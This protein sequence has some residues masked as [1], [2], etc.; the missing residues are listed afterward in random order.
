MSTQTQRKIG[1]ASLVLLGLVFIAAVTANNALL[2]GLRFDL[3]ENNLYT[4]SPG[5]RALLSNIEEPINLYYFFSDT[6]TSDITPLRNFATRVRELLEELDA[7]A[8][9]NLN[10][11]I[12]DPV[13]FS[14]DED[15]AAQFGLQPINLGLGQAIYFGLVGTNS[16]GEEEII[17]IFNPDRER[18]LEYEI[19]R[20]VYSLARPEKVVVGLLAG[21]PMTP[22]F[23]PQMQRPTEPWVIYTQAEQLFEVR[24][25]SSSLT[26]IEEEL[27]VLWLVHPKGLGLETLYAIDQFI[28]RGGR[29][30]IFL[31]PFAEIDMLNS[32]GDPAAMAAGSSSN[33]DPL[34]AAWG[35]GF[36]DT[37]VVADNQLALSISTGAGLRP[38]RHLGL[39]GLNSAAMDNDDVITDGLST[40]NLGST[41]HFTLLDES[42]AEIEPLL[43]SSLDA[44]LL[45]A[46]Q[47]QML[48]DPEMLQDGFVPTGESYILAA[49][50]TGQLTTAFPDGQPQDIIPDS[51]VAA[52]IPEPSP[53]SNNHTNSIENANVILVGD[54]DFLSDRLWVQRQNF[55]GQ[56]LT[57]AFASNGDFVINSLDNLSGSAELIGIRARGTYSRPFT[58]VEALRRDADAQFRQTEQL[59][60]AEL[61]ETETRLAELQAAR[62]DEG[63]LLASPEQQ[64]EV[65]RFLDQQI[66]IRQDLRAVQR[67]L[68]Q[69]I[70]RLGVIL[71]A[72]NIVVVPLLLTL[73]ALGTVA[74]RRKRKGT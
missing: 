5:T 65:Q 2:S 68:D 66:R 62:T 30:L 24:T 41:G 42:T 37:E 57:T 31:D 27:D 18:F 36:T 10:L 23:D 55:L 26:T 19:A 46:I 53:A 22:G 9:E 29:A 1:T 51:E 63:A 39:L 7:V 3:T 56:Q 38:I 11:N 13:P 17:S 71:Q 73:F 33:L 15:R 48:S 45:P 50:I 35:I 74:L 49:R 8:G 28:L 69:D 61:T 6:E 47:V 34:L 67:N 16:V 43:T 21:V 25:L 4:V 70:E 40:L 60:Q 12:I 72:I 14:E 59:L 44:A 54:V 20:M 32:G 58:R 64:A 52:S